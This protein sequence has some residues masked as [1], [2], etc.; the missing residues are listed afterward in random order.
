MSASK[1][2]PVTCCCECE[3]LL[4][5]LIPPYALP[6]HIQVA[7]EQDDVGAFPGDTYGFS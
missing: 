4:Q 2:M 6:Q 7:A 3:W 1:R 5:R